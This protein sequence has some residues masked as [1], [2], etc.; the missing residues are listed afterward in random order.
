MKHTTSSPLTLF[1]IQMHF[2]KPDSDTLYKFVPKDLLPTEYGGKA[3]DVKDIKEVLRQNI[4]KY[5]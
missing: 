3:G 4:D 1:I 5:R 2:H